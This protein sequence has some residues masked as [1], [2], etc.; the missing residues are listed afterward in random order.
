M[1]KKVI[2][3]CA[4][5]KEPIYEEEGCICINGLYYHYDKDNDLLNCYFPEDENGEDE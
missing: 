4:Y 3:Y 1:E 2:A 5:C